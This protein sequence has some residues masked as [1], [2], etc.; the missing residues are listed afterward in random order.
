[1]SEAVDHPFSLG[2]GLSLGPKRCV[3]TGEFRELVD[4]E[5]PHTV[6]LSRDSAGKWT[7]FKLPWIATRMCL[8]GEKYGTLAITG[9]AGFIY[10]V[11]G[12]EAREEAID[13]LGGGPDVLGPLR[14][15]RSIGSRIYV[16]GMSRQVYKRE[17]SGLWIRCDDGVVQSN[18]TLDTAGL[19]AIDGLNDD[20]LV[21]V[22]YGGEIWRRV[23]GRWDPIQSP[24]N[25]VLNQ[26]RVTENG[27]A[28]A[29]GQKGVLLR[30]SGANWEVIEHG[31]TQSELWDI[32]W[33]SGKVYVSCDT[34]LYVLENKTLRKVELGLG[35]GRS[36]RYLDTGFGALWS[37]GVNHVAWTGGE[38]WYDA[39]PP[40]DP[41]HI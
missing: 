15:M 30:G 18:P 17:D 39:T 38:D 8:T 6:I 20:E 25:V 9:P 21:A 7:W 4:L 23:R 13:I 28:Y 40:G 24:T 33:F 37:F 35:D 32:A 3:V 41:T 36:H 27:V 22:G 29:C 2:M 31:V 26:V 12:N 14:D 11:R 19:N 1:M 10:Q 16:V 34:A 5:N